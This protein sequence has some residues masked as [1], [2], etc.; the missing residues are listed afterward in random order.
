MVCLRTMLQTS[1][2]KSAPNHLAQKCTHLAWI[3]YLAMN[4]AIKIHNKKVELFSIFSI[5]I[6]RSVVLF[7]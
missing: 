7:I 4:N 6:Q 3:Y 2:Y 1:I 5:Y